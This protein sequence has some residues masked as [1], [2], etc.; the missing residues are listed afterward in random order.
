M[1]VAVAAAE[2]EVGGVQM[3]QM[4]KRHCCKE[5]GWKKIVEGRKLRKSNMSGV[6]CKK[7]VGRESKGGGGLCS[8][9]RGRE[10]FGGWERWR[11]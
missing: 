3:W 2:L 8:A 7:R 11:C 10:H 5:M 4:C 6:R 9:S 1:V